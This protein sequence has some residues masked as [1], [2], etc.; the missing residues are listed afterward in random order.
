MKSREPCQESLSIARCVIRWRY[1]NL[2]IILHRPVLLNLANRVNS[3][4]SRPLSE[5]ELLSVR[6]CRAVAKQIIEDIAYEWTP[7]QMLG[8]NGV[9]NIYQASMI[10]LVSMFL[11]PGDEQLVK[12]CHGQIEIVLATLDAMIGWSL[13]ARRSRE[14]VSKLYEASKRPST[15]QPSPRLGPMSMNSVD[16]I[17]HG[18]QA[19]NGS[20]DMSRQFQNYNALQQVDQVGEDGTILLDHQSIWDFDGMLWSNLSDGLEMPFDGLADVNFEDHSAMAYDGN[21]MMNG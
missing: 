10:P 9:W 18:V 1:L 13:A 17:T 7:N 12:E 2:R 5:E 4:Q 15:R 19:M 8:W 20:D 3:A 16:G 11:E 14:V 6:Q 21:Y